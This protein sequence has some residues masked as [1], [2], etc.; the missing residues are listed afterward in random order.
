MNKGEVPQE[1]LENN[2]IRE[3]GGYVERGSYTKEQLDAYYKCK[4][5]VMTARGM[6]DTAL[7]EGEAIGLVKGEANNQKKVITNGLHAG[8]SVEIM[9]TITGLTPEEV[10]KISDAIQKSIH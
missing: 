8:Y 1:L 5:D 4:I 7:T 3:A 6:I 10:M 9:S 2:D